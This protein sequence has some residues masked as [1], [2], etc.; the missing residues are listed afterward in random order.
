MVWTFLFIFFLNYMCHVIV[1]LLSFYFYCKNDSVYQQ[2]QINSH[3]ITHTDGY[4]I[5][6]KYKIKIIN[7]HLNENTNNV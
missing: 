4:Y 7:K 5:M 1:K 2:K 6:C 3:R